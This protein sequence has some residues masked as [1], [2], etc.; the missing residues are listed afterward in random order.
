MAL[1]MTGY[2]EAEGD[3][4]SRRL[5][6]EIRTVNHRFFHFAP[7]LP[8]DLAALEAS[9]RDRVRTDLERGHV[10]VSARWVEEHAG[11]PAFTVD[12]GRAAQV[13]S[14]LRELQASLGLAGEPSLELV[15]RQ[16]DVMTW[17]VPTTEP[18]TWEEVEP[19]FG[20]AATQCRA[21]RAREGEALAGAIAESLDAMD[22]DA[23][24][25]AELAPARLVRERD[26]LRQAVAELL[27][28][29]APDETRLAQELALH[30]DRLDIREEQVRLAAHVAACRAALGADGPV[31]K[32]LGFLAQEMGREV[33]TIGSKAADAEIAA[34]VI[35]LKGELERIREQLENLE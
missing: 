28:G 31:G 15:V 5:R 21:A 4:G 12:A 1:S 25:I 10:S 18:V 32:Q 13:L 22:R 2:G 11:E 33:N 9:I 8:S 23:A 24:R 29:T 6:A 19:V 17:Q 27:D 34:A 26:R 35:R 14:R 16:P 3:V 20:A 7:R 30:A